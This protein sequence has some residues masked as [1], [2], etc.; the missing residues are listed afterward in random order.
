MVTSSPAALTNDHVK[1]LRFHPKDAES[2]RFIHLL[3]ELA[4]QS[5]LDPRKTD[6]EIEVYHSSTGAHLLTEDYFSVGW[7]GTYLFNPHQFT[8]DRGKPTIDG[9]SVDIPL[10]PPQDRS[11]KRIAGVHL[12]LELHLI[13]GAWTV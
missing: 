7:H 13:S 3:L 11:G 5:E 2:Q 4:D 1:I 6:K 10:T 9:P 12:V 8:F